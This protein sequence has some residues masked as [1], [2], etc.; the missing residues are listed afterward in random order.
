VKGEFTHEVRAGASMST[1]NEQYIELIEEFTVAKARVKQTAA[2][3]IAIGQALDRGQVGFL[4]PGKSTARM[5]DNP[6]TMVPIE[7]WPTSGEI[8][9]M[10]RELEDARLKLLAFY[11]ALS[12]ADRKALRPLPEGVQRRR[13]FARK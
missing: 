5:I 10:L 2:D 1:I 8:M 3:L 6:E 11:D 7:R 9:S 13:T 12:P 4:H